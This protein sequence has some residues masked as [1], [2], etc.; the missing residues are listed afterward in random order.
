MDA[1]TITPARRIYKNSY[2]DYEAMRGFPQAQEAAEKVAAFLEKR[3][4]ISY[5]FT[6][7]KAF[8][9]E[10]RKVIGRVEVASKK[11]PLRTR[12]AALRLMAIKNNYNPWKTIKDFLY[13]HIPHKASTSDLTEQGIAMAAKRSRAKTVTFRTPLTKHLRQSFLIAER[14]LKK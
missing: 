8:D 3:G 9:A 14:A 10:N 13:I 7:N 11:T 2:I 12:R 4:N 6:M 5:H 1:P